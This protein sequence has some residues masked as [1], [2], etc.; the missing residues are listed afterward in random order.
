MRIVEKRDRDTLIPIIQECIA[1]G[2][3]IHSDEWG[4]YRGI[5]GTVLVEASGRFIQIKNCL[6]VVF[7]SLLQNGFL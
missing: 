3:E 2:T 5:S 1:Q 4:A 6:I 7:S